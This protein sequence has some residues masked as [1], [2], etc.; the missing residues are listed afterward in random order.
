MKSSWFPILA[1]SL[2]VQSALASPACGPGT[3]IGCLNHHARSIPVVDGE[4]SSPGKRDG[5][6]E[7][8]PAD[9]TTVYILL[10][11]KAGTT[12]AEFKDYYENHHVPLITELVF[13]GELRP[14]SYGRNYINR[15]NTGSLIGAGAAAFGHDCITTVICRDAAHRD[16]LFAQFTK[17]GVPIATDEAKFLDRS[18][19]VMIFPENSLVTV[20]T[21]EA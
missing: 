12:M 1:G 15:N 9:T 20:P 21:T 4:T 7:T 11:R 3:G 18:K 5:G 13:Q 14:L 19:S 8:I 10:A 6:M 16:A 17:Q 2:L